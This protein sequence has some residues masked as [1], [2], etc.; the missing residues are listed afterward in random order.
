MDLANVKSSQSS[1]TIV[2]R[3][4]TAFFSHN[5]SGMNQGEAF[6]SQEWAVSNEDPK[7]SYN[8]PNMTIGT[9]KSRV[10]SGQKFRKRITDPEGIQALKELD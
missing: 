10:K 1:N 3:P 7:S 5:P 4:M 8:D 6:A 9:Q 2:K